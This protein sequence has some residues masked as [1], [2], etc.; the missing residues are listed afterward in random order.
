M[1]ERR[2]EEQRCS[3][4]AP[5]ASSRSKLS[6]PNW[7]G[8]IATASSGSFFA[9]QW[10]PPIVSSH[11]TSSRSLNAM[12]FDSYVPYFSSSEPRRR[13]PS[14]ALLIYGSTRTTKSSSPSPPGTAGRLPAAGL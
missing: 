11:Q 3:F 10:C 6:V 13:T 4:F 14:L 7:F 5:S 1:N 2:S 8:F 12:P 9:I